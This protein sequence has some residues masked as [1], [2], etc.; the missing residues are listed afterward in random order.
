M[1]MPRRTWLAAAAGALLALPTVP[2]FAQDP[3]KVYQ[4]AYLSPSFDISDAWERVYWAMRG[5]LDELGIKHEVQLLAMQHHSDHAGQF[6]QVQ[7]VVQ[8]GVDYVMFGPAEY[9]SAVPPLKLMKEAGIPAVVYN[10]LEPHEDESARAL[11]YI[12]FDHFEGG[13]LSG[14]WAAVKLN[15]IGK[16]VIIQGT[17][18]VVSDSRRDGFLQIIEQF[19]GIEVVLGPYTNFDRVQAFDAMQNVLA[20]HPD[21]NLVYGISTTIGLGAA[22]AIRQAGLSDQIYSM[23]FGGTADEVK[24]MEE[25]WFSASV[26]RS[27]DDS[28]VAVADAFVAHMKGEEAAPSWGGPFFMLDADTDAEEAL[29][30]ATRYSRVAMGR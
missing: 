17:A 9:E 15:G 13:R 1:K 20:A 2:A 6:D 5:R 25:G 23:G 11:Q 14:A 27:I 19:P 24:A 3:D 22:Q 7:S 30:H 26:G 16:I 28:G 21:V 29:A 12:A 10:F 4:I 8:R 18:G